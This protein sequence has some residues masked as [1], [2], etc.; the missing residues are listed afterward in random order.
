MKRQFTAV[1]RTKAE[2]N[3][4]GAALTVPPQN[5]STLAAAKT[6]MHGKVV[7]GTITYGEIY[8]PSGCAARL[9]N[10]GGV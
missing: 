3:A 5:F 7:A 10:P 6:F 9:T 8:G 4:N 2:Q 1:C